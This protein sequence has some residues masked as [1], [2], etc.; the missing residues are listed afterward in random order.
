MRCGSARKFW[1]EN[2]VSIAVHF[3]DTIRKRSSCYRTASEAV[4]CR[5]GGTGVGGSWFSVWKFQEN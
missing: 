2:I 3:Q 5:V 1:C 4:G